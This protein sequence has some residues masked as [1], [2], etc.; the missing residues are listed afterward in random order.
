MYYKDT[1]TNVQISNIKF[2]ICDSQY[3][4]QY[5]IICATFLW[6]GIVLMLQTQHHTTWMVICH[7]QHMN[8][9]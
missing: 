7:I 5:K 4:L 1:Q 6:V 9:S 8:A 3:K 2:Y